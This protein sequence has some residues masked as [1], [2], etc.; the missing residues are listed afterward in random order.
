MR[1]VGKPI[2]ENDNDRV[3]DPASAKLTDRSDRDRATVGG[4][5]TQ[6]GDRGERRGVRAGLRTVGKPEEMDELPVP[7]RRGLALRVDEVRVGCDR[8]LVRVGAAPQL[9][10][11]ARWTTWPFVTN[12]TADTSLA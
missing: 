6:A 2:Q 9:D 10:R 5:E 8:E 4:V 7:P 3:H 11:G 1:A 12:P